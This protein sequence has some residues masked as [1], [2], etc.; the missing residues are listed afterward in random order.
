MSQTELR[1]LHVS[2]VGAEVRKSAERLEVWHN[3]VKLASVRLFDLEA[4]HLY[5]R[6]HLSAPA[7]QACVQAQVRVCW[8]SKTRLVA[9]CEP[10]SPSHIL[11]RI[12]QVDRWRDEPGRLVL[13]K[14]VVVAKLGAQA[15]QQLRWRQ[16]AP[17]E[18][19]PPFRAAEA[20]LARC[21]Q[22]VPTALSLDTLRGW[23][24]TGAAAHFAGLAAVLGG[25]EGAGLG[26][27]GRNARPPRDPVNA[28]LSFGYVLLASEASGLVAGTGL[29]PAIGV[30]HGLRSGRDSL[31]LDLME[32]YRAPIVDALVVKLVGRGILTE[33]H[34]GPGPEHGIYLSP[35]GRKLFL[36]H[37]EPWLRAPHRGAGL[38]GGLVP[39]TAPKD[40]WRHALR[41]Q[42]VAMRRAI[43]TGEPPPWYWDQ[44]AG[45]DAGI[46]VLAP[47]PERAKAKPANGD[48]DEADRF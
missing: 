4:V 8:Y 12:A 22:G 39:A 34:F 48:D 35:D 9:R 32:P 15:A 47:P 38:Y 25:G 42:A 31:A 21:I 14:S 18:A 5:G 13:A 30:L 40:C 41:G 27:A 23:E 7:L 19:R 1:T 28:L 17:A 36:Q 33:D 26:F 20:Q 10:E 44:E 43:I 37:W 45:D 6:S 29:D 2:A 24:G 46:E 11:T 16:S 3:K